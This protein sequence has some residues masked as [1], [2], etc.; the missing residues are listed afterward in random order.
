MLA[1]AHLPSRLKSIQFKLNRTSQT[2][3]FPWLSEKISHAILKHSNLLYWSV[4]IV[5][6]KNN[7]TIVQCTITTMN[8]LTS[9]LLLLDGMLICLSLLQP[10]DKQV[11]LE[12]IYTWL[13]ECYT[14]LIFINFPSTR[15]IG[16]NSILSCCRR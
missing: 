1:T 3:I 11:R 6:K 7:I 15:V 5:I 16:I 12:K 8:E 14:I 9:E 13:I 10:T 2:Q 4:I